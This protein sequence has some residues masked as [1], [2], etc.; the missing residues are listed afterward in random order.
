MDLAACQS[1]I[2]L[3]YGKVSPPCLLASSTLD[4][5]KRQPL[6]AVNVKRRLQYKVLYRDGAACVTMAPHRTV[7][8]RTV[9]AN[10]KERVNPDA[11]WHVGRKSGMGGQ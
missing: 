9:K 7:G 10:L 5:L 4:H 3:P 6:V 8:T 2:P 11:K 1:T